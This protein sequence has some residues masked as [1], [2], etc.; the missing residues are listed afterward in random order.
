MMGKLDRIFIS[1]VIFS[2]ALAAGV[3]SQAGQRIEMDQMETVQVIDK[4]GDLNKLKLVEARFAD[5][6]L[7]GS[8]SKTEKNLY[9]TTLW[10]LGSAL[11]A[12]VGYKRMRNTSEE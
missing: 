4:T 6:R 3:I 1:V 10:L 2:L 8:G 12:M 7:A 9:P 5:S 11:L